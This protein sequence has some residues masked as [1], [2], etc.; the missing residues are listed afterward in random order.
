MSFA[1]SFGLKEHKSDPFIKTFPLNL[2]SPKLAFKGS[3]Y[4]NRFRQ[5]YLIFHPQTQSKFDLIPL[6]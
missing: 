2:T 1:S 5:V 6:F 3:I 4:Q